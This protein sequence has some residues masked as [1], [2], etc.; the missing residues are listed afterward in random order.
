MPNKLYQ[1]LLLDEESK[2]KTFLVTKI[3]NFE[4]AFGP[5]EF[6]F[7]P[8]KML[9]LINENY[10]FQELATNS[11]K[12]SIQILIVDEEL[13]KPFLHNITASNALLMLS[14][15]IKD[16]YESFNKVKWNLVQIS[17]NQTAYLEFKIEIF[18]IVSVSSLIG[19]ALI[20]GGLFESLLCARGLMINKLILLSDSEIDKKIISYLNSCLKLK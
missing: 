7:H 16:I 6:D 5:L 10:K 2:I 11:I 14:E 19:Q 9:A 20:L 15:F 13:K 17:P 1:C 12:L 18:N 4:I 8:Y 3:S